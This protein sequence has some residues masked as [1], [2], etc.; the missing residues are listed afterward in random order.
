[1]VSME[2]FYYYINKCPSRALPSNLARTPSSL[3]S[4]A[5]A[6][7]LAAIELLLVVDANL[8]LE[9]PAKLSK[10]VFYEV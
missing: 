9:K 7:V 4:A 2:W 8:L 5:I 1:M 3:A 10:P 6:L